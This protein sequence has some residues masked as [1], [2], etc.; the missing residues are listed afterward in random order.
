[1]L[2][3]ITQELYQASERRRVCRVK[4]HG[5]PFPRMIHPFGICRTPSNRIV[6]VCWQT[7]GFT[8]VGGKEGY[9]NLV[10]E[11]VEEVEILELH[12]QPRA[13]FNPNDTQ[14]REW[15]YHI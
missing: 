6:V 9:R 2:E 12:F 3:E 15:V 7:L 5:E 1:M 11:D 10:L 13:D 4:M 8:K 14:Y